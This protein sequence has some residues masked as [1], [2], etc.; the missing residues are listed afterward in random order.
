MII[1]RTPLRIS[2]VGGGTD[3]PAFYKRGFGAVVSFAINKYVYVTLNEKFD[4]QIRASY[5]R[6][7]N[8]RHV[9]ELRHDIIR[10][11]LLSMD[12]NGVEVNTIA[13]IPGQGTGLGSSSA[14]SVGLVKALY[15][16]SN[17][18]GLVN[19]RGFADYAYHIERNLCVRSVGKQD[20]YASAYGN[21]HYFQ[22]E[23]DEAVIAEM[24]NLS[25]QER[26]ELESRFVLLWTGRVRNNGDILKAQESN[27]HGERWDLARSMR[28]MAVSLRDDLRHK[29]FSKIGEYLDANWKI[30][31]QLAQ[32]ISNTW[33]DDK[34]ESAMNVGAEGGKLCGA[35]GGGFFLFYGKVG[36]AP[37]LEQATGLKH[38]PFEID[39]EGSQVIYE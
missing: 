38:I 32:G 26:R 9:L 6:T 33:I 22:F 19:P 34:Y 25:E 3:M 27:L 39:V 4:G 1:T 20:H 14:L 2:L 37:D 8:V 35:G 17:G 12:V 29:D 5:S 28:D 13:D 36:L 10:E 11:S 7:E 23:P 31:R 18:R 30:K 24:I 21:L 15:K 16:Y